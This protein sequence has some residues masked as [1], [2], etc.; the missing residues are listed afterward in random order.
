M[1]E[2]VFIEIP[3]TEVEEEQE[4]PSKTYRL[5]LESGHIRGTVDGLDAVVQAIHKALITPRWKCLAYDNQY[6]NELQ[7]AIIRKDASAAYIEA[8]APGFI[9]DALKPDTRITSVDDFVFE[10]RGDEAFI[11]FVVETIFGEARIEEVL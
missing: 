1:A 2:S 11:S 10:F 8:A 9:K 5:D 4:L 3:V 7:D 6:G